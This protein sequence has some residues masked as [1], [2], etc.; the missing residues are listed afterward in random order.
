[1][2]ESTG[3]GARGLPVRSCVAGSRAP[4]FCLCPQVPHVRC[5]HRPRGLR[6]CSVT[7]FSLFQILE[8][9]LYLLYIRES[10]NFLLLILATSLS[11]PS[12]AEAK[13]LCDCVC[14]CMRPSVYTD[15]DI[16]R[17]KAEVPLVPR[18]PARSAACPDLFP[19]LSVVFLFRASDLKEIGLKSLI[20][21]LL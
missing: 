8:G 7:V 10:L 5:K 19:L 16:T 12:R 6:S 13:G 9:C 14:A 2:G 15:L 17:C 11:S 20:Q 18:P 4:S 3:L 21:K 1:M